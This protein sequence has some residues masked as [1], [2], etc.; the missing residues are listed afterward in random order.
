VKNGVFAKKLGQLVK[1]AW[2][3]GSGNRRRP[4][5]YSERRGAGATPR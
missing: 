2:V 4:W 1:E 3:H 5:H